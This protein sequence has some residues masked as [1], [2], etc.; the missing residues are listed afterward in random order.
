MSATAVVR[1]LRP[2]GHTAATAISGEAALECLAAEQFDIV[3]SDLGMG[4]GINGWE[5]A[6][7]VRQRWP[8]TRFVLATGWGRPSNWKMRAP[9]ASMRGACHPEPA[10]I[11]NYAD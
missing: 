8:K 2:A 7:R 5:L 11:L 1:L 9:A 6:E 10:K 4:T 3:L